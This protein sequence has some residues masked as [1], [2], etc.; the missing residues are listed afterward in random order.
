MLEALAAKCRPL[1]N[2][3]SDLDTEKLVFVINGKTWRLNKTA[4]YIMN[5]CNGEHTIKDIVD[6]YGITYGLSIENS[7]NDVLDVLIRGYLTNWILFND[8]AYCNYV[9]S[10]KLSNA[11]YKLCTLDESY[12]FIRN[13]EFNIMSELINYKK[14]DIEKA[15][16][17]KKSYYMIREK[18]DLSSFLGIIP[19][20]VV[21]GTDIYIA[22]VR[23]NF[24]NSTCLHLTEYE[25]KKFLCWSLKKIYFF[26]PNVKKT[27]GTFFYLYCTQKILCINS[28]NYE[29]KKIQKVDDDLY[30]LELF[31]NEQEF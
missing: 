11:N 9:I 10:E 6:K 8:N 4:S 12:S 23:I 22:N 14:V 29:L 13:K 28:Q 26:H 20:F 24:A 17:L 2:K 25:F 30:I 1:L 31:I 19:N 16:H 7:T 18:Y 15:I 27:K 5:A 21:K 3:K